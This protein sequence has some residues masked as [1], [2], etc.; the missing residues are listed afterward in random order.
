[1]ELPQKAQI[2][3]QY[4]LPAAVGYI[5]LGVFL[6]TGALPTSEGILQK[7]G[8]LAAMT[9]LAT[10]A[11][12]LLPKPLKEA[13]VFTRLIHRLPGHRA[14]TRAFEAEDRYD[15]NRIPGY[16]SLKSLA[17]KH[18]QR[19]FYRI[20]RKHSDDVRVKHYSHRYLA[21]RDT[22]AALLLLSIVTIPVLDW[23]YGA[24]PPEQGYK[25]AG[26]TLLGALLC[27]MAARLSAN[28]LVRQVL[29]AEALGVPNDIPL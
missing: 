25:L 13:F 9:L 2:V 24:M 4:I 3:G 15:V 28:E 20:Y 6:G 7:I 23:I 26:L 27:A 5:I 17:P 8:G 21:W 16:R 18:Q 11:Q 12:D 19:E 1:V 10:L 29:T 22:S 14:F